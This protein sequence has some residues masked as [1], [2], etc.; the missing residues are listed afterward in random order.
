MS[1]VYSHVCATA[2]NAATGAQTRCGNNAL[3]WCGTSGLANA[4]I[5]ACAHDANDNWRNA[6]NQ[7]AAN[8]A[9]ACAA[10]NV[11]VNVVVSSTA[12]PPAPPRSLQA[13]APVP[14]PA[15]ASAPAPAPAPAPSSAPAPASAPLPAGPGIRSSAV[16]S[17][18]M[19]STAISALASHASIASGSIN[20]F[21][22]SSTSS[23]MAPSQPIG[24]NGN[25]LISAVTST[26][27]PS[28]PAA[29][30]GG[31]SNTFN[32]TSNSV[33]SPS[34]ASQNT[35]AIVGI[36]V[37]II[38]VLIVS[39]CV[40][41]RNLKRRNAGAD[42]ALHFDDLF[43]RAGASKPSL[44]RE[45]A[46]A[47]RTAV[48]Q[49]VEHLNVYESL[50]TNPQ[51]DFIVAPISAVTAHEDEN[52][53]SP[54]EKMA[55]TA[56]SSA[57]ETSPEHQQQ[58]QQQQI[59]QHAAYAAEYYQQQQQYYAQQQQYYQQYYQQHA[60]A[61]SGQ[62]AT[63]AG[64]QQG[65]QQAVFSAP[66]AS[67]YYT[68]EQLQQ[69]LY[70]APSVTAAAGP[71]RSE[72]FKTPAH[73]SPAPLER[74]SSLPAQRT[75]ERPTAGAGEAKGGLAIQRTESVA[76]AGVTS[77]TAASMSRVGRW[78][79]EDVCAWVFQNKLAGEE[80]CRLIREQDIDGHALLLLSND[81]METG[82]GLTKLGQRVKFGNAVSALKGG[83]VATPSL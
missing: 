69:V 13:P 10:A 70:G 78:S 43:R 4:V 36:V 46:A 2:Q 37:G 47:S 42:A 76:A 40:Y 11:P 52:R 63:A 65:G 66:L 24:N 60:V 17:A 72:S 31:S 83:L 8:I 61:A 48:A 19:S 41:M 38:V 28:Y 75:V 81:D 22:S 35:G 27:S 39:C 50:P 32:S 30:T 1:S 18:S 55:E 62:P 56:V 26:Q 59:D 44:R 3:C 77:G 57:A 29:S 67:Q 68:P 64:Y 9:S 73:T 15:P 23:I 51:G 34:W 53:Y 6:Y 14:S 79:A 21:S 16:T 12:A 74:Q 20:H 82:L 45:I 25:I 71:A 54:I 5:G 33:A 49:K 7:I 58:I 80:T